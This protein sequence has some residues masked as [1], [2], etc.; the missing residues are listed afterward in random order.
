MPIPNMYSMHCVKPLESNYVL[1]ANISNEITFKKINIYS[2]L[3]EEKDGD[4]DISEENSSSWKNIS[5]NLNVNDWVVVKYV[6]KYF[7]GCITEVNNNERDVSLMHQSSIESN[8]ICI[9]HKDKIYY[10]VENVMTKNPTS[11]FFCE[12]RIILVKRM[13]LRF[14]NICTNTIFHNKINLYFDFVIFK[15]K[16]FTSN[17]TI[18]FF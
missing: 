8:F 9:D 1:I 7:P 5:T 13:Y 2:V 3:K 12:Q 16:L 11:Y 17:T 14:I 6:V 15:T 18:N 4:D 10:N